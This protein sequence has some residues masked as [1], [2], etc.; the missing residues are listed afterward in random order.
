MKT[1]NKNQEESNER[2]KLIFFLLI[3]GFILGTFFGIVML[4]TSPEY[5]NQTETETTEIYKYKC[6]ENKLW[7]SAE[8]CF[9]EE[10]WVTD[11]KPIQHCEKHYYEKEVIIKK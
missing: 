7:W 10:C 4:I 5:K 2:F 6:N 11:R 9:G 1:Q 8:Q 3:G